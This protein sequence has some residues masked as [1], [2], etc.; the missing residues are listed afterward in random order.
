MTSKH[1]P[2]VRRYTYQEMSSG[3]IE[4]PTF[5]SIIVEM[6]SSPVA[7]AGIVK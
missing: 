4:K 1:C 5:R 3:K 6:K 7:R 2:E